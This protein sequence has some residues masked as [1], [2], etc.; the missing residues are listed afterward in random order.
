MLTSRRNQ[1]VTIEKETPPGTVFD[2]TA[3]MLA[4][5]GWIVALLVFAAG[6]SAAYGLRQRKL[7]AAEGDTQAATDTTD[8]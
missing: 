6:G 7:A 8:E 3:D 5:Y 4:Q 1:T 2:K